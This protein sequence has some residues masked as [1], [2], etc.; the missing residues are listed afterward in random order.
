MTKKQISFN[1]IARLKK[2]KKFLIGFVLLLVLGF[3]LVGKPSEALFGKKEPLK[4]VTVKQES[5]KQ[6]VSASG[7]IRAENSAQ[8]Q[9]VS[10]GKVAWMG[11]KKG[12]KVK[13]RQAV[14]SL[15]KRKLE[16][17]LKQTMLT[18]MKQRWGFE[19]TQDDYDI[20][21]RPLE[22]VILTDA[23]KRIL[24]L[25]QFDLD[26]SVLSV[27]IA[28]ITA[29]EA[30]LIS[31]INGTVVDDGGITAGENLT[32]AGLS[33]TT[34]K[35]ID[36]SSLKFVAQ[37][38]EVDY[39]KIREGQKVEISL[40]AFPDEVFE[41]KVIYIGKEGVKTVG[42]GVTISID[43]QLTS[44]DEKLALGL[45]G[46]AG[47]ILEEKE[48]SLVVP[49]EY[50]KT[51]NGESVVYILKD[52]QPEARVVKIGLT[53]LSQMEI[54]EGLKKGEEIVLVKNNKK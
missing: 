20:E 30:V 9:F 43:I 33:T 48:S 3:F 37:V 11:V 27:E 40:D 54:L 46:E 51:K 25:A 21:G 23:E 12:D 39:G 26:I 44:V 14:A 5:I 18:Y 4:T 35:I 34:I 7:E 22:K 31:P 52:N 42:G 2:R 10:P 17:S 32:L 45:T 28:K 38:D 16:K 6:T 29:G 53:T 49:K 47:F 41:G 24:E 19:Q 1:F 13:K 15:D 8:L 36:F 50:V